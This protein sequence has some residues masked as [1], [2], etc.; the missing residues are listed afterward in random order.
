M[1]KTLL[2]C[3]LFSGVVASG[4]HASTLLGFKAGADYWRADTSGTLGSNGSSQQAHSCS[5][6]LPSASS[7]T[8]FGAVSNIDPNS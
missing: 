6:A 8:V 5:H 4:A 3:A 7:L 2:A 1:K